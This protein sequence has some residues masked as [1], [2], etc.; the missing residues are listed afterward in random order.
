MENINPTPVVTN[1][2]VIAPEGANQ[3]NGDAVSALAATVRNAVQM[4]FACDKRDRIAV[5]TLIGEAGVGLGCITGT[6]GGAVGIAQRMGATVAASTGT[7][8]GAVALTTLCTLGCI[9][10]TVGYCVTTGR[11]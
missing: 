2:P 9:I 10:A 4:R 5:G 1:Q 6:A 8:T 7:A 3:Q 11:R